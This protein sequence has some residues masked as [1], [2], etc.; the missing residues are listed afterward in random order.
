M[1]EEMRIAVRLWLI[2]ATALLGI[3]AVVAASLF[4]MKHDLLDDREVKSRHIVE[5]GHSLLGHFQEME[6]SG[7]MSREQAQTAALEAIAKLRYE[8]SEYLWIHR[9]EG[10]VMLAH[11]NPKLVGQSLDDMKDSNGLQF[12]REMNRVIRDKS[13]GFVY[14]M[15]PKPGGTE[16]IRKLS[17]VQGFAPWGWAV[18]T[19]IYIDDVS[20]A[21]QTRA[22]E[23]AAAAL[24]ILTLVW[25]IAGWVSRGITRPLG[26]VTSTLERLTRD[27]RGVR[28]DHT[29]RTDEIGALARGLMVF[30]KHIEA[31]AEAAADKLR[32]QEADLA[33]QRRIERLTAEFD[34][35][36]A[37]VIKSVGAAAAQMQST[38]QS[39]SA[40]ADQTAR[41]ST[42]VAAAANHAA[43]SVQTVAAATEELH[44]SE[45]EIA[46]Q[47]EVSTTRSRTAV[48]EAERSSEIVS[49]LNSA[50]GRIGEVVALINDIASQTNLLAL[51]ATIE[52]ARAGEAGKGF[53]VVANE[54]KNLAN[55]TAKAT[56]EI[57]SQIGEVQ[58]AATQ[59]A[60]AIAAIVRTIAEIDETSSVVA[61]AVD[62]QSAAT[63]EIARS[64]EQA[65]SGTAEVSSNITEVSDAARHAGSTASEVLAAAAELTNQADALRGEVEH[66]LGAIHGTSRKP[67]L[68]LVAAE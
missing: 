52:A 19:G 65:A 59:A 28:I 66:F 14:Y 64:I 49:G 68:H 53:A 39:M 18:G 54:V 26:D 17:Y 35:K 45:A 51:N 2:V 16:P 23:F 27:D 22:L 47:V 67:E 37:G 8:S 25:L 43:M 10:S 5:V 56:D 11:P 21:F 42:A 29:E 63:T 24:A 41:Q 48:E 12:F 7:A 32:Q 4:Q 60:E 46:R 3:A 50:A 20:A 38:S 30:Q 6:R 13:A 61:E 62:Q 55:Q 31:A 44:A 36:V 1:G 40:I 57:S 33:R 9:I 58:S 15:W 34:A